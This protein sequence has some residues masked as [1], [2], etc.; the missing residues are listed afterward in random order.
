MTAVPVTESGFHI[1][2]H[3]RVVLVRAIPPPSPDSV[4]ALEAAL[5][6]TARQEG[7]AGLLITYDFSRFT[8][9]LPD[10]EMRARMSS[11]IREAGL[12]GMAVV[13]DRHGFFGSAVRSVVTGVLMVAR[14]P[15]PVRVFSDADEAC[16]WLCEQTKRS[17]IDAAALRAAVQELA[18]SSW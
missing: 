1:A 18:A 14:P 2:T 4:Q 3:G 16:G 12:F 10:S 17:P 5:R 7:E 9:N 8:G 6:R 15:F 11:L 13:L